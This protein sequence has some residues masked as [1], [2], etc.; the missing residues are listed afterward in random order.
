MYRMLD[1]D[2][3]LVNRLVQ[4]RFRTEGADDASEMTGAI[5]EVAFARMMGI[6]P[7]GPMNIKSDGGIDFILPSG[8]T[9][10]VKAVA[11]EDVSHMGMFVPKNPRAGVYVLVWY[12]YLNNLAQVLGWQ[13]GGY[14]VSNGA[15]FGF[16][17]KQ[18]WRISQ[19]ELRP[20]KELLE[21]HGVEH[22]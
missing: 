4:A 18:R 15:D 11:G 16:G 8:A 7:P 21:I 5:G 17:R 13:T 10:D 20:Y 12:S 1:E 14:A 2:W 22:E 9:C 19:K 3:N 6:E